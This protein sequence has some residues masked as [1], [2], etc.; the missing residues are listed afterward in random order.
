MVN[1]NNVFSK[2]SI[3]LIEWYQKYLSPD[4]SAYWKKK[5]PFWYCRYYPTCS[6]YTKLSIQ[7]SWFIK[8]RIKWIYRILRCNPCSKWWVDNP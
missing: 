4:H 1:K 5:H 6:E 2:Y 7:K 3:K 8:W